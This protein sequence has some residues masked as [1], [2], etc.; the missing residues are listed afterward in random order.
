MRKL[1]NLL[2]LA[3]LTMVITP[4][5][6]NASHIAGGDLIYIYTG[7]PNQYLMRLTLYRDCAGITMPNTNNI[8]YYS[9]TTNLQ[10]NATLSL[11]G[12][13][14]VVPQSPCISFPANN[15]PGGQG[16][17]EQY[18][19]E[20]IVDLPA[21][22][23]DWKFS[24]STCCRNAAITTLSF[25][26]GQ[27]IFLDAYLDNL[28]AP[29]NSSPQFT[30]LSY[31]RFCVG[32][33][34][35]YDQGAID[36]DGDSL[37]FSLVDPLDEPFAQCPS[38]EA[39]VQFVSPY[40]ATYPFS[41]VNPITINSTNGIVNFTP[42]LVQVGVMAVLVSEYRNGA[43]IGTVRRDIQ[44]N[45]ISQCNPILPSFNDSILTATPNG[46]LLSNCN[47]RTVILAFDTVFQCSSAIPTDFRSFGPFGTPNP[48]ISAVPINCVNGLTDSIQITFLN[49]LSVGQTKVWLKRGFDGNTLLSECGSEIPEGA[50]TVNIQVQIDNSTLFAVTDSASCVFN[51]FTVDLSDSVYCFSIAPDGSDFI[52]V[53]A[54]GTSFPIAA[55]FGDCAGST[56]KS[57]QLTIQLAGNVT[58][59]GP[60]YLLANP[61][62][63]T[64]GNGLLDDCG[65]EYQDVDTIA[66]LNIDNK[67]A[68]DLGTDQS[69]CA[70]Q[71]L[72]TLNTNL[73]G[74]NYQWFDQNG[75]ISGA[76][77]SSYQ[78]TAGGNYHVQVTTGV[79]G[80]AGA[81]T[82]AVNV[83][84]APTDNLPA[85][86]SQ[87][88]ND[89]L[90]LLDAGNPG[91]TYVWSL[92]GNVIAGATSQTYQPTTAGTYNV[93]VTSASNNC[94]G[95]FD[96]LIT[97][98]SQLTVALAN[99][100]ICTGGAYPVLDA[101]NPGAAYQWS[102]NGT[103]IS[104][105]TS[106]TYQTTQAGTYT[107]TVGSGSCSGTGNMTLQVLN[108]PP[109]P[110]V[111]C[112]TGTGTY[113]YV[114]AWAA[115]QGAVS[116]E[117][118]EDG[119]ATWIAANV[120]NG[121]ETHG[122]MTAIPTFSVRAIGSGL[123]KIGATS[124]PIGC[125]VIIPNII[126]PNGDSKNE[127]FI[128]ANIEGYPN[129]SVQIINR[130]GKEVY[131]ADGYNNTTKVFKGTDCPDG[132]YFVIVNLNDGETPVKTGNLTIQR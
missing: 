25:S 128:I 37:V 127:E 87:C 20:G 61:N 94:T 27:G 107:V 35:Y 40:S 31:S 79:A 111:D 98:T 59:G 106:Q 71:P 78:V 36:P 8:C 16:D 17:V 64:D 15:C 83:I 85:D 50:D 9:A 99:D 103:A 58:S 80:C 109:A 117:V 115:V 86:F 34:F 28:T 19:Y 21:A 11:V 84:P 118:T 42:N 3:V 49:P 12:N 67:I 124:E 95:S 6:S 30:T 76:T 47:E 44:I 55:A 120:P 77:A 113:K 66:I 33:S 10:G 70:G 116:Y 26:G 65:V 5:V 60:V 105:A 121:P 114:Y 18:I 108:Y 63:S 23:S 13:P 46:I 68:V 92:D 53:D 119:G 74:L 102:L 51:E 32:N 88:V 82:V 122:T 4:Q 101:G 22:A 56:L 73:T 90:P 89:P 69:L 24:W 2:L 48:V 130:W 29:T 39:P 100:S 7:T 132:V 123:C 14:T 93:V 126:T 62:P 110:V 38:N 52:V 41:S 45:I 129:N 43:L 125:E 96:I 75:P 91:C 104:G 57:L 1:L 72:P 112:Q 54:A 131:S 97:T 81:D